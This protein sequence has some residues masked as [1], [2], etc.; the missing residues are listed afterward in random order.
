M[1]TNGVVE[2]FNIVEDICPS[3]GAPLGTS[4]GDATIMVLNNSPPMKAKNSMS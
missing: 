1:S 2:P 4:K 3:V